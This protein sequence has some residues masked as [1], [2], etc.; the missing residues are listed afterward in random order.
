MKFR[1]VTC[2]TCKVIFALRPEHLVGL[3]VGHGVFYCP[4]G[5]S[6]TYLTQEKDDD[7]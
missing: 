6:L 2:N 5:H 3:K 7:E 1:R 4:N